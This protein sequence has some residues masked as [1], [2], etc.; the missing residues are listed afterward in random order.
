MGDM[1]IRPYICVSD[2]RAALDW[3]GAVF[4]G[5]VTHDPVVM[6]DGRV[7]HAETTIGDVGVMLSEPYPEL[8]VEEPMPGR[9]A[10][11][12]LYLTLPDV[13]AV[14]DAARAAGAVIDRGP[15]AT[16]HGRVVVL[17]D[18]FG[19]RWMVSDQP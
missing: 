6:D 15:E 17:R 2:A 16:D 13:D 3:Y 12:T 1:S 8:H 7:G 5:R 4:G 9:G 10:P 11:V 18:P 19:H 14:A